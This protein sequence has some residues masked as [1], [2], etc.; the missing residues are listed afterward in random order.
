MKSMVKTWLAGAALG[1]VLPGALLNAAVMRREAPQETVEQSVEEDA[2]IHLPVLVREDSGRVQEMDMDAYLT[3]VVRG[4]MPASFDT[5][6]LKAQAVAARTYARKTY[7]TGG[8]HGDGSV[9]KNPGCCQAYVEEQAYLEGGGTAEG[10]EKIR[11]AVADTSGFVLTYGGELIEATYF[12]CSGGSTEDAAAVW[13]TDY[14]YLQAVDSPGEE[15]AARYQ[16][17]VTFTA[18][19][20]QQA[21]GVELEGTPDTWFHDTSFTQGGGVAAMGI[22]GQSYTG[23]QLRSRLGLDSTAFTVESSPSLERSW[24]PV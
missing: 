1:L 2:G 16:R 15:K 22:G 6:A 3:G 5:E 19:E 7:V 11:A 10:A 18:D 24:V 13:G 4:E 14:P 20:F 9:C 8:K 23:T 12:S 17:T 21:L